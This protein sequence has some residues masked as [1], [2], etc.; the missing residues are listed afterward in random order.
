MCDFPRVSV[1]GFYLHILAYIFIN[2]VF[3][4]GYSA[5]VSSVMH[6]AFL[7]QNGMTPLMQ[8]AYKGKDSICQLL[9]D[10]GADVNYDKHEHKV[11]ITTNLFALCKYF[12]QE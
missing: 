11:L 4:Y 2:V 7:Q 6:C 12:N 10:K 9:I 1:R 8:A 3:T 5:C